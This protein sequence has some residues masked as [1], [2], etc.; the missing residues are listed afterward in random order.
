[1]LSCHRIYHIFQC[2]LLPRRCAQDSRNE[3]RQF[4]TFSHFSAR[5]AERERETEWKTGYSQN[6]LETK[7]YL[8]LSFNVMFTHLW[9]V[10]PL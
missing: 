7:Q 6:E 8:N 1:M 5:R 2:N 10:Q 4:A 9:N 3:K